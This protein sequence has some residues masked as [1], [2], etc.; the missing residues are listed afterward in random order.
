M[1]HY[2]AVNARTKEVMGSVP[3]HIPKLIGASCI[4]ELFALIAMLFVD[5]D[6][7][8]IFL[9]A[10]FVYYFVIYS[11]YRNSSARH[12]H[13]LET[14][15][16]TEN[17]RK[18]DRFIRQKKGLSNSIMDGANNKHVNGD[19]INIKKINNSKENNSTS[20]N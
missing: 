1:L 9:I 7:N 13:E 6:Y 14:K 11:R 5:F 15:R 18:V 4:V 19:K 20:D 3:I 16:K 10:G 2:V 12:R 17:M 8:W